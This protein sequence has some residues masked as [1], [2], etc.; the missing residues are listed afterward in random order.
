MYL[1]G[2]VGWCNDTVIEY[3]RVTD[4]ETVNDDGTKTYTPA[5]V[6]NKY[7]TAVSVANFSELFTGSIVGGMKAEDS[8]S[9]I[10]DCYSTADVYSE[11]CIYFGVGLGLGVT[12]GYTGGLV[13]IVQEGAKDGNEAA[14]NLIERVS[15]AGNLSSYNYNIILL[16][17]PAIEHDKYLGGITGRGGANATI[18]DA[19]YM[20]NEN[21]ADFGSS[22]DEDIY[23]YK[24]SY[25][26]GVN[27]GINFGDRDGD[28]TD[29]EFWEAATLTLPE[30]SCATSDTTSPSWSRIRVEEQPLQQVGHGLRSRHAVHGGSVK[31]TLDCPG[32]GTVTIGTTSLSSNSESFLKRIVIGRPLIRTTSQCRATRRAIVRS[33]S[34]TIALR[35][36]PLIA[37][38]HPMNATRAT[39]LWAGTAR[40]TCR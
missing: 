2:L 23:D 27:D 24:T 28:Y 32:S 37:V 31:A 21:F 16:G 22:T 38:G 10:V 34:R 25:N 29:R 40:A 13:G 18:A 3:S 4:I 1:G 20:R 5:K 39:G 26:G 8:G 17:I 30:A 15:F 12:R 11:A 35:K 36:R 7:G 9:K 33:K 14:H 19:Y 6:E